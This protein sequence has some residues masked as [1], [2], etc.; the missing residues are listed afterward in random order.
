MRGNLCWKIDE[1]FHEF[2]IFRRRQ[3]ALGA[4]RGGLG[5]GQRGERVHVLQE[6]AIHDADPSASLPQLRSRR[7]R[8]LLTQ[9][10]FIAVRLKAT[11]RLHRLLR[12][13]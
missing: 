3:K 13:P 1:D 5:A 10:V 12:P 2:L 11:A 4:P 6:D 7:V 9:E 8:S